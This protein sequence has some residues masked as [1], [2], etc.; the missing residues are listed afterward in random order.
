MAAV[1]SGSGDPVRTL[2]LLWRT[3]D[4]PSRGPKPG[5]SVDAIVSA[6]IQLADTEGL[7]ALSM[8][9]VADKLGV[10]T[11]SLYTYVPAKAELIDC[12]VDTVSTETERPEHT[13][14]WRARLEQVARQN[15]DLY[16][17][18]PWLL[19]VVMSRPVIG[20][21]VIAKW[22]YE[23]RAIDGLG[24]DEVEMDGVLNV[25]LA[26]VE[27]AARAKLQTEQ[28]E[29]D[30]G[31]TLDQ[32][33]AASAPVLERVMD[34]SAFPVASRVGS[35]TGEKYASAYPPDHGFA[36]GLERVLDGVAVLVEARSA[37]A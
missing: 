11:M 19:Q 36:F 17:R 14:G 1:T 37:S 5:L 12:M 26:H 7:G 30:S 24:L 20:P 8:R 34:E 27:G 3:K 10:G 35:V 33:W 4:A 31:M 15:W 2:A 16:H 18:H 23:L 21:G 6:A 22:D 9:K 28:T 13:G 25:V 32:W 29:R